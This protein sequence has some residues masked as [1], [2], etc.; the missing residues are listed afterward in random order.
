MG[1][2]PTHLKTCS[3]ALSPPP[4]VSR[5]LASLPQGLGGVEGGPGLGRTPLLLRAVLF[6]VGEAHLI[7][8]LGGR[9][10]GLSWDGTG[11]VRRGS[12]STASGRRGLRHEELQRGRPQGPATG[13]RTSAPGD[14]PARPAVSGKDRAHAARDD[15]KHVSRDKHVSKGTVLGRT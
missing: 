10:G 5:C 3:D 9:K 14:M 13:R 7:L 6:H 11:T 15:R 1:N 4:Q 2:P 8:E 12:G